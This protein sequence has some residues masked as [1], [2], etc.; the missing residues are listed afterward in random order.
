MGFNSGFKGL[1][2][3]CYKIKKSV[4]PGF[5]HGVQILIQC[6]LTGDSFPFAFLF[7]ERGQRCYIEKRT[8]TQAK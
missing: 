3:A 4:Y 8:D 2:Q 1:I 5:S 7:H 6:I